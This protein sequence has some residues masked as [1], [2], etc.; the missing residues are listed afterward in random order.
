MSNR[1]NFDDISFDC[2]KKDLKNYTWDYFRDDISAGLSVALL[3]V[4]QAMAYSLVAGVPLACGLFA[5]IFSAIIAAAFGSSRHLIVG[6]SNTLAVLIQLAVMEIFYTFYRDVPIIEHETLIIHMLTQ[7]TLLVGLLQLFIAFCKLGRLTQFVSHSVVV[8]YIIGAA[9]AVIVNQLFIFTGISMPV[10]ARSLFERFLSIFKNIEELHGPTL[11]LGCFSFLLLGILKRIDTRIPAAL[12]MLV[13]SA[14]IV[15]L[16]SLPSFQFY[17]VYPE[18]KVALVGDAGEIYSYFP[19]FEIPYFNASLMNHLLPVAFAI[20]LLGVMESSSIT[21]SIAASSGQRL[22]ITQ[23]IFGLGLGNLFSSFIGAMPI[24]GSPSR[25]LLNYQN[26]AKTRFSAIFNSLFAFLGLFFFSFFITK[27]PQASLA[28]LLLFSATNIISKK[29][30]LLCLKATNGDALV[31]WTTI[32]SCI[33]FSLDIAFYIGVIVSITLYLKKSALPQLVEFD[34]DEEG[35]LHNLD[36]LQ[37]MNRKPIRLIKVEGEL[38]FGAAEAFHSTLKSVAED[39]TTT[40]VIILQLKNARDMDAT[41]CL[42]L[43][44]LHDFLKSSGRHLIGCGLTEPIWEVLSRADIV[45]QIGKE[46]LFVF[47]ERQPQYSVQK[48]FLRAK[49]LI[50][51][52]DEDIKAD[53]QI[54]PMEQCLQTS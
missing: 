7:L 47:D 31:L 2:L 15:Y 34:V 19:R 50:T 51:P 18:A 52:L 28:A 14:G 44:Q 5:A 22:S 6:P 25:S 16:L 39:D 42:A 29:Q 41:A 38:F 23:E 32:F 49:Q 10:D 45:E 37:K 21:K 24:T 33:F 4:P 3:T 48:A 46:N 8:G 12:V 30:F 17:N 11:F 9:L 54:P 36:P 40:K 13:I 27:I 53:E 20:A 43:Q 35:I 1:Q 26:K